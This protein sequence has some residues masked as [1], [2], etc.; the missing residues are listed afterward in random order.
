MWSLLY[1]I[2]RSVAVHFS[3]MDGKG[4]R[5]ALLMYRECLHIQAYYTKV[6]VFMT[7][8]V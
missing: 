7:L 6:E 2:A 4:S 1:R 3:K 8:K 5:L